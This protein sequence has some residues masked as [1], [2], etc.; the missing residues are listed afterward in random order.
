MPPLSSVPASSVVMG[1]SA[2]TGSAM[3]SPVVAHT[4]NLLEDDAF[5][6]RPL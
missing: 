3:S 2:Q 4:M 6:P 5:M 1:A